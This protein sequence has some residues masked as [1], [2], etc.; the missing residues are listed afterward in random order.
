MGAALAIVATTALAFVS[1]HAE[2]AVTDH[3]TAIKACSIVNPTQPVEVVNAVDDGSGVGFS[4]I[5]LNDAEGNLWMCDADADG[6]V[7][8]YSLV[9]EDLVEG[10]GAELLGLTEASLAEANPQEVAEKVCIAYM[11]DGG[12]VL[13][14]SPDGY[15]QYPG[16]VVFVKD[17]LGDIYLCNATGSDAM[18]WAFEPIGE[19]L[20]FEEEIS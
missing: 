20:S 5:W 16:Y 14:S 17:T 10:W 8:S 3:E 11:T 19:P 1:A 6:N 7:Y 9:T 18:I 13:S 15:G 4:L 2:T 12:E